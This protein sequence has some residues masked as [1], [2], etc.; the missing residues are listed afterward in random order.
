ML[1]NPDFEKD[2]LTFSYDYEE[3]I[4]VLLI[5]KNEEGLEKPIYFFIRALRDVELK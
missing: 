4:L 1:I 2:F 5:Q 3:T